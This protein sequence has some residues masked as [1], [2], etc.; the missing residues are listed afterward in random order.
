MTEQAPDVTILSVEDNEQVRTSIVTWLEDSGFSMLEAVDGRE[1][2]EMFREHGPDLVLLDMGLPELHGMEVLKIIHEESPQTPVIIVSAN[3]DISDAIGAFKAGAWDY[4]TKPI[5]NFDVLEQT[6]RNSLERL[7][8]RRKIAQADRRYRDL[9]QNLPVVVFSLDTDG[10]LDFINDTCREVLGFSPEEIM[11]TPDLFL[12]RTSA[13]DRNSFDAALKN[14]AAT[15]TGFSQDIQFTHKNGYDLHLRTRV[16]T[17]HSPE[18]PPPHPVRGIITDITERKFLEKVLVQREKINTLGAVSSELAHEIRN[19]LMSL[20]GFARRMADKYPDSNEAQIVLE[21]A[22]RIEEL[23]TRISD[24]V[25]PVPIKK[26][27]VNIIAPL[28]YCL[29]RLAPQLISRALDIRPRLN[30]ALPNIPSDPE[31][32]TDTLMSIMN[33]L[34]T[35]MDK[36]STLIIS[37]ELTTSHVAIIFSLERAQDEITLPDQDRVLMPFEEGGGTVEL[38]LAHKNVKDLDG[39]LT[40][41]PN[42]RDVTVN[43]SLPIAE[44]SH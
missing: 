38:A 42:G 33:H 44:N 23:V 8:L 34:A 4:V 27:K 3:A 16:F 43:L 19:P 18:H 5:L 1:G 21:Q 2:V 9:V 30:E 25:A 35:E 36:E 39:I 12:T 28:T 31:L 26:S 14:S 6:I 10:R 13:K 24:Y 41:T 15:G 40:V 22:K 32:L 17:I 7:E 20:G 29:D 37:T 11:G